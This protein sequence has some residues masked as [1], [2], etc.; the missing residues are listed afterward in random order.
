[1]SPGIFCCHRD[2][3]DIELFSF[4]HDSNEYCRILLLFFEWGILFSCPCSPELLWEVC[5]TNSFFL[6]EALFSLESWQLLWGTKNGTIEKSC[7]LQ[8]H[9]IF[10]AVVGWGKPQL[11]SAQLKRNKVRFVKFQ[12]INSFIKFSLLIYCKTTMYLR[13]VVFEYLKTRKI[14]Y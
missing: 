3:L 1:M 10:T 6:S 7:T 9:V 11:K 12:Q 5:W 14:W 2:F 13:W 4:R 8:L